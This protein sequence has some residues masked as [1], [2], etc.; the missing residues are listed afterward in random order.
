MPPDGVG[1]AAA[2]VPRTLAA[3]ELSLPPAQPPESAPGTGGDDS[4][5]PDKVASSTPATGRPQ[6]VHLVLTGAVEM[7]FWGTPRETGS[8]DSPAAATRASAA[9][10]RQRYCLC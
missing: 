7:G 1:D 5:H 9:P 2:G 10:N 3:G 6:A 4:E 8:Q